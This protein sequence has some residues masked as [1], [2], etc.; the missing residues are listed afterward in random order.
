MVSSRK[1][2][3]LSGKIVMKSVGFY[4]DFTTHTYE[5]QELKLNVR[6]FYNCVD[7]C[8]SGQSECGHR[9]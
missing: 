5:V 3:D 4:T 2:F 8:M 6:R 1:T 7:G 9:S